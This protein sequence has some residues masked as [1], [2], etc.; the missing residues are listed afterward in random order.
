M[1]SAN[2][3]A[4]FPSKGGNVLQFPKPEGFIGNTAEEIQA[5]LTENVTNWIGEILPVVCSSTFGEISKFGINLFDPALSYDMMMVQ[6]ACRSLM[7]A[8]MKLDHPF[9]EISREVLEMDEYGG[10]SIYAYTDVEFS[11]DEDPEEDPSTS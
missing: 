11:P 1:T 3:V 2:S 7:M 5:S 4:S 10:V 8:S 6:E 9:Q